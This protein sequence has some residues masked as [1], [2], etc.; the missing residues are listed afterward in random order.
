MLI[1][2]GIIGV[3]AAM[4]IP[5]LMQKCFEIQTVTRFKEVSSILSQAMKL[6][7][8]ENGEVSNWGNVKSN[9]AGALTIAK[10]LQPHLKLAHDCGTYDDKNLC[11]SSKTYTLKNGKLHVN[12]AKDK[13]YYKVILMN[14]SSIWWRGIIYNDT[15]NPAKNGEM[16]IITYF[17]DINGK[18]L[19]NII[20]YD[21]F[22]FSY[23]E[24]YG[25]IP[26]GWDNPSECLSK[27]SMGFSCSY[28]LFKNGKMDYIRK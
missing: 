5:T 2:L 3:V 27:S 1:T 6:A 7:I 11:L 19:P 4:T 16:P 14:G 28:Y 9:E 12:Y 18:Q 22:R 20:G 10:N 21:T 24:T 23:Y 25:L 15:A 17:I 26:F 8:E 13:Q